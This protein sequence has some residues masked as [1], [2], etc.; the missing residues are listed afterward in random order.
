MTLKEIAERAGVSRGTIDRVIKNRGGVNRQTERRVRRILQESGYTPNRA[1][2]ALVR[3]KRP[4]IVGV[5][6]NSVG[7]PFFDE[8]NAGVERAREEYGDYGFSILRRE[9]K[10]YDVQEQLIAMRGLYDEVDGLVF[11]PIDDGA[12]AAE[13]NRFSAA[14]KPVITVTADLEGSLRDLYVGCDYFKSGQT[15][16]KLTELATGGKGDVAIVTGSFKMLGHNARV[17]GFCSVAEKTQLRVA[18]I[19]ECDD[20]DSIAYRKT[21]ALLKA[22]PDIRAVYVAA[23]GVAGTVEAVTE[24]GVALS[25]IAND[26]IP[27]TRE[28][29]REGKVIATIDQQPA[30]QGYT[31]LKSMFDILL[32]KRPEREHVYTDLAIR[33]RYN[34]D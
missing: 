8:V 29:V 19:L 13:A 12:I 7:N 34:I 17:R 25:V 10:G 31:A 26:I 22:R 21:L 11:T 27:A 4:M 9:I 5:V 16:A 33:M 24:S 30:A 23:A 20:D 18:D 14:G 28:Y 2:V 6:T 3:S 15:A 32:G 1:G